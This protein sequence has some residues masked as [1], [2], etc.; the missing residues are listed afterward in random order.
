MET[1]REDHPTVRLFFISSAVWFV[2]GTSLGFIDATHMMAPDLLGDI[3]WI[4]FSRTRPMH[5]NV[6]IYGFVGSGLIGAAF[7]YVPVLLNTYLY[8]QRLGMVSG[9]IYNAG[10]IFGTVTLSLGYSQGREYAEWIWPADIAVLFA[11]VIAIFNLLMTTARRKEKILYV[12]IWYVLA[13]MLYQW[14]IYFFGNA[15]WHPRTGAI[16]G[17]P[18]AIL[19]WF[20]GHGIVGLFL[21][22]LAIAASY[23][24]VP[25]VARTPL[26]SHKMSLLG[27]WSILPIYTHIGSHHLLQTP[28]PDWLKIIS[29]TGS[30]A[31]FIPVVTVLL[32]LWL[33]MRGRLGLFHYDLGAKFVMAGLV[34]Y[35]LTCIQGPLQALPIVQRIT[36]LTNWT[37][38]H[39]HIA[40][41]GFSGFISL[42]AMYFILPRIT[43]RPVYNRRFMD[44]QY[45]LVLFGLVGFFFV[46][47]A[48]GLIQ[49]NSWR[50][51]ELEYKVLPQIHIYMVLRL[52]SGVLIVAGAVLGLYNVYRTLYRPGRQTE[53]APVPEGVRT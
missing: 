1:S 40:V 27:F 39:S 15:V 17:L 16:T 18:D 34:W 25:L 4:V 19:A 42:G 53:E 5:T 43:G 49:G 28:V 35:M 3:P 6:V 46:L 29:V 33:T 44:I 45:W 8:S 22:P 24:I 12:A 11:W 30:I 48:A 31:M 7:Y 21:T 38:G 37:I 23:F 10:I 47:T 41:L 26:Y 20:Y 14:L 36:H 50:N 52:F 9:W 51:G 2:I 13:G 32:N